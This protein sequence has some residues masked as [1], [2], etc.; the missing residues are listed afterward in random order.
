M[1]R[2]SIRSF[3]EQEKIFTV[4]GEASNGEE[5]VEMAIKIQPD[6]IIMDIEMPKLNGIEATKRIKAV[7]PRIAILILTAFEYEQYVF[8]LLEA[9]AAGYLLK[10]VSGRELVNATKAIFRGESILH[11]TIAAKVI[12]QF[13]NGGH[14]DP[15]LSE[16][17][18]RRELEVLQMVAKGMKNREIAK[19]IYVS[20]RTVEAHLG[21]IFNK[22]MVAS[23][24]EAIMVALKKGLV[25]ID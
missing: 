9:G 7:C 4:V 17:L 13:R 16:H 6:V 25:V 18:T 20:T 10:D 22:L 2:E 24:T 23:R 3:L 19:K 12:T 8:T 21:H 1:V 5:A 15:N 11:P 14:N